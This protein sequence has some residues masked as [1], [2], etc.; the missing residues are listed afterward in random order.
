MV[1]NKLVL[2]ILLLF[3]SLILVFTFK[4]SLAE[5]IHYRD[6]L[7][8]D[9]VVT[10]EN[11]WDSQE[12]AVITDGNGGF[13][14]FWVS[15]GAYGSSIAH[16]SL[17]ILNGTISDVAF[18]NEGMDSNQR[19]LSVTAIGNGSF[20]VT[21]FDDYLYNNSIWA[22]LYDTGLKSFSDPI[23]VHST[24]YGSREWMQ[25]GICSD[26]NGS[27]WIAWVE[28]MGSAPTRICARA[29]DSGLSPISGLIT[30]EPPDG[31][32]YYFGYSPALY[33]TSSN[34][35]LLVSSLSGSLEVLLIDKQGTIRHFDTITAGSSLFLIKFIER[36]DG[37][38]QLVYYRQVNGRKDV[39]VFS[40]SI[41]TDGVVGRINELCNISEN[42]LIDAFYLPYQGYALLHGSDKGL[43]EFYI[44]IRGP[45]E[46]S[47]RDPIPVHSLWIR[48]P[49][50]NP[51]SLVITDE[52]VIVITTVDLE[53]YPAY[54]EFM[55][56]NSININNSMI[57]IE[58]LL[59]YGDPSPPFFFDSSGLVDQSGTTHIVWVDDRD[60]YPYVRYSAVNSQ[61]VVAF[62]TGLEDTS[63]CVDMLPLI[64]ITPDGR[65]VVFW[66]RIEPRKWGRMSSIVWCGS[67]DG[68]TTW[69]RPTKVANLSEDK[70]WT[71]YEVL[72]DDID[73]YH[74]VIS[75]TYRDQYSIYNG[76]ISIMSGLWGS[77]I[78]SERVL[79]PISIDDTIRSMDQLVVLGFESYL[80]IYFTTHHQQ[81]SSGGPGTLYTVSVNLSINTTP[82]YSAIWQIPRDKYFGL[83][84]C[85]ASDG[86]R[87]IT[88]VQRNETT[89]PT[90]HLLVAKYDQDT[91][92]IQGPTRIVHEFHE[93]ANSAFYHPKITVH[94]GML[95]ISSFH[96]V[97]QFSELDLS[98]TGMG[99][100]VALSVEESIGPEGSWEIQSLISNITFSTK[101]YWPYLFYRESFSQPVLPMMIGLLQVED[102]PPQILV[103]YPYPP[104]TYHSNIGLCYPNH[105]PSMPT[106]ISP[107]NGSKV[108]DPLTI[109]RVSPSED[110]DGD[111]LRYRF[112]VEWNDGLNKWASPW[113]AQNEIPFRWL[114]E[115]DYIWTVEVRDPYE[116]VKCN[117][118]W[119]FST[120]GDAPHADPGGPY[121]G[122]EGDS[123]LL[124]AS[125]SWDDTGITIYQW[126]LDGDGSPDVDAS[127]PIIEYTWKDDYVGMITLRVTDVT[128][129]SSTAQTSVVILNRPPE[130]AVDITGEL[131]EG[132]PITIK[133][134]LEGTSLEDSFTFIW[135]VDG[136]ISGLGNTIEIVFGDDGEYYIGL[137]VI[138]DDDGV[139]RWNGTVS[140]QNLPPTVGQISDIVVQQGVGFTVHPDIRDVPADDLIYQWRIPDILE[141]DD[142]VLAHVLND[143]GSYSVYLTVIDDD[144]GSDSISFTI[145]VL[146]VII[147]VRLLAPELG[148]SSVRLRWSMHEETEFVSY[149]VSIST[150]ED[151]S[152]SMDTIIYDGEMVSAYIE[153]LKSGTYYYATVEL[154]CANGSARSN[155]IEFVTLDDDSAVIDGAWLW[156]ALISLLVISISVAY[157]FLKVRKSIH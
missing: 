98:W 143:P 90:T 150:K 141:T 26:G 43:C 42:W 100:V 32:D 47:F 102:T 17:D 68:G 108:T 107:A 99:E 52:K 155:V 11:K 124:N 94:S 60:H 117:W 10:M 67:E 145:T 14:L 34:D 16:G 120:I 18:V 13:H 122:W 126:D 121:Q 142:E 146:D 36:A 84:V 24:P 1:N 25:P 15:H 81:T 70:Y 65:I 21:W 12:P 136:E 83:D 151:F 72:V 118:S 55:F 129:T 138:D 61:G 80:E 9:N 154:N 5:S 39:R 113:G 95:M 148:Y 79:D 8:I 127:S 66:W 71:D 112:I 20:A 33:A 149:V 2:A 22:C 3:F 37:S 57:G 50:D 31:I 46:D 89:K 139:G 131:F 53:H 140:I 44:S 153:G 6:P 86:G 75:G 114:P 87:W 92:V 59:V 58:K 123:I 48:D 29:F 97:W 62:S 101:K 93:G 144:G 135:D 76:Y 49:Y 110:L 106:P 156:I 54:N 85:Q 103:T 133:V 64:K 73:G 78:V 91:G 119:N 152:D 111:E 19:Y 109:L 147:P 35:L 104:H 69:T 130:V 38:S 137:T 4:S 74:L 30:R 56:F 125:G 96:C 41:G 82:E 7:T 45:G 88:W 40:A 115:D 116:I 23:R 28:D 51:G 132:M 134:K 157:W 105:R 77:G 27:I 63:Y 128:G